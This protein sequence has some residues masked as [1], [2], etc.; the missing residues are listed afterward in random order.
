MFT[1][2]WWS[3]FFCPFLQG[4]LKGAFGKITG[5]SRC[6][7]CPQSLTFTL[8]SPG[9]SSRQ[10][11][12]WIITMS[13]HVWWLRYY[14]QDI[15]VKIQRQSKT[16]NFGN[17]YWSGERIQRSGNRS[18]KRKLGNEIKYFE[19]NFTFILYLKKRIMWCIPL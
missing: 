10:M 8:S 16:P 4:P 6:R 17:F 3:I 14:L 12:I 9:F 11:I 7:K 2:Q 18:Q 5:S 15:M 19:I 1:C 13:M